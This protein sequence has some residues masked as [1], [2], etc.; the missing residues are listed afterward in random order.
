VFEEIFEARSA[1]REQYG[2]TKLTSCVVP[3]SVH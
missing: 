2:D 3:W 1:A